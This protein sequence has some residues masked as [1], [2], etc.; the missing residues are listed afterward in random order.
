MTTP[1]PFP[2]SSAINGSYGMVP[3]KLRQLVHSTKPEIN[4]HLDSRNRVFTTLDRIEGTVRITAV[5]DTDFDNIDIEFVGTARTYVERLTTAAAISGRSEA[6]HNFLRLSQPGLDRLCP[7]DRILRAGK[8]YTFPFVFA[9]PQQLLPHVCKHS[10][11]NPRVRDWHCQL[12]PTFGDRELSSRDGGLDDMAPEMASVRYGIFAKISKLSHTGDDFA[13]VPVANK[14]R[15]L[16]VIPTAE[17][18]PPLDVDWKTAEVDRSDYI[19]RKEKKVKKGLLKGKLGT[20]VIEAEQPKSLHLA[21]GVDGER[22]TSKAT[23]MLRFEPAEGVTQTPRLDKLTSKLKV[24]TYFAAAARADIPRKA[25]S[26][27]DASKGLHGESH[28]LSSRCIS[29]VKWQLE[30]AATPAPTQTQRRG[31]AVSADIP[32]SPEASAIFTPGAPVWVAKIIVPVELPSTKA[33]VPTFHSCLISRTYI[34]ALSLSV[35]TAGLGG[36]MDLRLPIQVS[37]SPATN[38]SSFPT[39]PARRRSSVLS[40]TLETDV[41]DDLGDFFAPRNTVNLHAGV[42]RNARRRNSQPV[43]TLIGTE[44]EDSPPEFEDVPTAHTT[45]RFENNGMDAPPEYADLVGGSRWF[46]GAAVERRLPSYPAV[47]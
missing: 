36:S 42:P 29:D 45:V 44:E 32:W 18:E 27:F 13:R 16:R 4:I 8:T 15:R 35:Q 14:A 9:V 2:V 39:G 40:A 17:E 12:P 5:V 24:R 25:D 28:E 33:F 6:F 20:L 21:A 10:V 31:S 41:E 7:A 38:P 23:V 37:A 34:L 22:V 46:G 26:E 1:P 43:R 11:A 3:G 19:M 30:D 47:R